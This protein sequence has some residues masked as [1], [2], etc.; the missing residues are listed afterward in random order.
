MHKYRLYVYDAED[1]LIAPVMPIVA[2]NDGAATEHAEQMLDGVRL[3]QN[4]RLRE[5]TT[6][7]CFANRTRRPP[8]WHAKR[9]HLG[10]NV[11][12]P[13]GY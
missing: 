8:V 6:G 7:V 4:R 13:G 10:T 3:S 12:F 5:D 2:D 1:R 11:R 9:Q